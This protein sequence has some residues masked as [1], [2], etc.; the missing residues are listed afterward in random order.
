MGNTS[1]C[2]RRKMTMTDI[3]GFERS[4]Y[5]NADAGT[6][7]VQMVDDHDLAL[8]DQEISHIREL[9][10]SDDFLLAAVRVKRWNTDLSP[11]T[12]P[13]VFGEEAFGSGAGETLQYLTEQ[14]IPSLGGCSSSSDRCFLLGG[15]S[16]AGLFALW[17]AYQTGLFS[18]VA[19]ASPSVW[20]PGFCSYVQENRIR[21]D[22]VYLSLGDREERTKN[23]V[24]SQVG[25]AIRTIHAHLGVAGIPCTLEWNKGNHFKNPDLRT[26]KAF[27]WLIG[28]IRNSSLTEL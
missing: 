3:T 7:L 8:I 16:L 20:F 18:G 26:A 14:L 21:T 25:T 4:F 23:P 24:M 9:T 13:P 10:G 27:A 28:R 6:V 15:Y 11:W 5:G 1:D 17:S 2:L 19:A 22:A 12:A